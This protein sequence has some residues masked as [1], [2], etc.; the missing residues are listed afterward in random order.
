MKIFFKFLF[1]NF[2]NILIIEQ[3]VYHIIISVHSHVYI[4]HLFHAQQFS[5]LFLNFRISPPFPTSKS[6][7]SGTKIIFPGTGTT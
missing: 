3:N 1:N 7:R 2:L 5:L 6:E 4:K